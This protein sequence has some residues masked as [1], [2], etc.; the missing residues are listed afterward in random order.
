[1]VPNYSQVCKDLPLGFFSG[2]LV[3]TTLFLNTSAS[4]PKTS[5]FKMIDIWMVFGLLL[6]F[7]EMVLHTITEYRKK[8]T[9]DGDDADGDEGEEEIVINGEQ[10]MLLRI[11]GGR[12]RGSIPFANGNS[13]RFRN[14]NFDSGALQQPNGTNEVIISLM[15]MAS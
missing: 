6:P 2:M 7:F 4:L 1:M 9:R 8:E 12:V 14:D 15:A 10:N 5:Y 3:M 13:F 11:R